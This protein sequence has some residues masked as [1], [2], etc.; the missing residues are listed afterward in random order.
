MRLTAHDRRIAAR[1][2]PAVLG[3]ILLFITCAAGQSDPLPSWNDGPAKRAILRF[4]RDT[5]DS[6]SARFIAPEQRI[7]T[8][9]Q[10]GTL[11]VEQPIYSQVAFAVDQMK[12]LAAKDSRLS[13]V[14]PFKTALSG[15]TAALATI[16][17]ADLEKIVAAAHPGLTVEQF[18][19]LVKDWITT[20]RH[21]RF[22]RPYTDLVYQPMLEV[23]RLLRANGFKTYIVTG[24]EQDF[25]RVYSEKAYGVPVDQ[26]IGSMGETQYDYAPDGRG[27][28]TKLPGVVLTDDKTG[29][30]EGIQ[31]MIGQRPVLAFGNS[32][33]DQ[34]MLEYTQGGDGA[35]LMLL[36]HHDDD[37]REYAYGAESKVGNFSDALMAEARQRDWIVVS[38]KHDWNRIFA[39]DKGTAPGK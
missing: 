19:A 18:R 31:L 23:M 4:V 25:V 20:A 16:S 21:P 14:E 28:L 29:K 24:S 3:S 37:I 36:V 12:A 10:D 11:L 34:Q 38:M 27:V 32:G 30:P 22:D 13:S 8:F 7:A 15:D 2:L 26:V 5:T 17:S 35:H 1:S 39:F 6:T 9:D 33:G